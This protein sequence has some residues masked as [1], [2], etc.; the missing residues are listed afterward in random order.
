MLQQKLE[1]HLSII[2][3]QKYLMNLKKWFNAIQ[4]FGTENFI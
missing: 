2:P 4:M 3:H 1:T